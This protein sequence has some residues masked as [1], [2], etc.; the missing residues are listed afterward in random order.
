MR[1]ILAT[2]V[3]SAFLVAAGLSSAAWAKGHVPIDMVQ[4]CL[5]G[6]TLTVKEKDLAKL[7]N[8]KG[9][10]RLPACDFANIFQSGDPCTQDNPGGFCSLSNAPSSAVDATPACSNPY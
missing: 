5:N 8:E 9:A 10:C 2:A 7:L 1:Q 3:G 4:V 6:E